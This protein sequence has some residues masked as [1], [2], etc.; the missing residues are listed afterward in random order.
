MLIKQ[1]C[2][3]LALIALTTAIAIAV[4]FLARPAEQGK[5]YPLLVFTDK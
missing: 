2:L 5:I 4:V 1:R 3:L